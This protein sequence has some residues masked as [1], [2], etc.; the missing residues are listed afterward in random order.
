MPALAL[1]SSSVD[2]KLTELLLRCWTTQVHSNLQMPH[3]CP[4]DSY[5]PPS[6]SE[7]QLWSADVI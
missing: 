6:C 2:L 1:Q 5:R 3:D 4:D 7:L